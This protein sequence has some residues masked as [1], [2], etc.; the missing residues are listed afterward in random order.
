MQY[1]FAVSNAANLPLNGNVTSGTYAGWF[2]LSGSSVDPAVTS[3]TTTAVEGLTVMLGD[4]Q[5]AAAQFF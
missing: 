1:F 3:A 5:N 2:P 4:M